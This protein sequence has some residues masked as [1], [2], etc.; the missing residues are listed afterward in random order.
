MQ[1]FARSFHAPDE[2]QTQESASLEVVE[3]GDLTI[4][5]PDREQP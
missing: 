1:R 4:G 5:R 2:R 3:L